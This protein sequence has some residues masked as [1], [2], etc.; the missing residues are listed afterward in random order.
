MHLPAPTGT[1][2]KPPCIGGMEL[3]SLSCNRVFI[4]AESVGRGWCKI[5]IATKWYQFHTTDKCGFLLMQWIT[6]Q[7]IFVQYTK[8]VNKTGTAVAKSLLFQLWQ[9][10]VTYTQYDMPPHPNPSK[11]CTRYFTCRIGMASLWSACAASAQSKQVVCGRRPV[12]CWRWI[13]SKI[14]L[15]MLNWQHMLDGMIPKHHQ[16]LF[17]TP[18]LPAQGLSAMLVSPGK[19]SCR[20]HMFAR[21]LACCHCKQ[22]FPVYWSDSGWGHLD[23]N[24]TAKPHFCYQLW[25]IM[26]L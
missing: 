17:A 13:S 18:A 1:K 15:I 19:G 25:K 8:L 20:H 24:F 23:L 2:R 21:A 9:L 3:V 10:S 7:Y 6:D 12:L 22:W 26:G 11:T 14:W 4:S 16:D 5:A